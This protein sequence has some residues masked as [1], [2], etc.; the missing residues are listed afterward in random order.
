MSN[1]EV[2]TAVMLIASVCLVSSNAAAVMMPAEQQQHQR[3][4]DCLQLMSSSSRM[5]NEEKQTL[6]R[7][8]QS[9]NSLAMLGG[10][11]VDSLERFMANQAS[12]NGG[13]DEMGD[14]RI[15]FEKR[16]HEYLRFG[17]K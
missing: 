15:R 4:L 11:I 9:S 5:S 13:I 17:R 6:C 12:M 14:K 7:L 16:K 8:Y 3:E 10:A 1:V 2:F